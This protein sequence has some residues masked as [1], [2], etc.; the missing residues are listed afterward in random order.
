VFNYPSG[1]QV[2]CSNI[3]RTVKSTV[4]T[5]IGPSSSNITQSSSRCSN[6]QIEQPSGP[7]RRFPTRQIQ[8]RSVHVNYCNP[9][10]I[11]IHILYNWE[12]QLYSNLITP[13]SPKRNKGIALFVVSIRAIIAGISDSRW[14]ATT[15][16]LPATGRINR[17][18]HAFCYLPYI[19]C[20]IFVY[21]KF[22]VFKFMYRGLI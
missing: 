16:R 20:F 13:Y 17:C 21:F 15:R 4:L 8:T 6:Y 12:V 2:H 22:C 5:L 11:N 3:P 19:P 10:Q 18:D 9:V 14:R 7:S 1:S